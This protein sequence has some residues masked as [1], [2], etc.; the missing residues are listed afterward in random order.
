MSLLSSFLLRC[1]AAALFVVVLAA[2]A[3]RAVQAQVE[4]EASAT[5]LWHVVGAGA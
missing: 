3:D 1:L 5:A 2:I 4:R